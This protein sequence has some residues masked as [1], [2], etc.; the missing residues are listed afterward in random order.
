MCVGLSKGIFA[1][2]IKACW[3]RGIL[4]ACVV[5]KLGCCWL[6][7]LVL[8]DG[9]SWCSDDIEVGLDDVDVDVDVDVR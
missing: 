5:E 8:V 7:L 1:L 6:R 3:E 4:C 9:E 2:E